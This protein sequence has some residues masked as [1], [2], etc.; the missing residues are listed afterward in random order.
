MNGTRDTDQTAAPDN[1]GGDFN[2]Q[3]AAS[4]LRQ[5]RQQAR[6]KFEPNPPLLSFLRAIVLLVA[7]GG[8]WLSVRGQHP[9]KGPNGWAIVVAYLL[10]FLVIGASVTTMKRASA[11]ITGKSRREMRARMSVLGVA[12]I[13]VYVFQGA[14]HY[15]GVSASIVYGLYPA[16]A[17]FMIV[18]LVGAALSVGQGDW[19]AFGTTLAVGV[20]ATVAAF[21]GPVGAWLIMGIGL[22]LALL[23]TG[24][25]TTV[26]QRA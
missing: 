9:Y 24:I 22:S 3:E 6:R 26:R 16:T 4:L 12:W 13:A 19:I 18:G 14:L 21:G 2:P 20:V 11:G 23:A 5:T 17:P 15:A 8:I 10:V 7:F 25:A 1:G